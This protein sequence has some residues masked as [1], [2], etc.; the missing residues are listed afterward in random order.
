MV[1]IEQDVDNSLGDRKSR[2]YGAFP[3]SG[4]V[5]LPLA[6][7]NSGHQVADGRIAIPNPSTDKFRNAFRIMIDEELGRPPKAAIEAYSQRNGDV[8]EITTWFSIDDPAYVNDV[9]VGAIVYENKRVLL[10]ERFA[11]AAVESHVYPEPLPGKATQVTLETEPLIGVDWSKLRTVVY[12]ESIPGTDSS[13]GS[14][15]M[16]QAVV[17]SPIEFFVY[18]K[19][20]TLM[21]DPDHANQISFSPSLRGSSLLTWEVVEDLGW[22]AVD[23]VTAPVETPPTFTVVS[24]EL[25]P[26]WQSGVVDLNVRSDNHEYPLTEPISVRVFYGELERQY[27]PLALR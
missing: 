10:T 15:D 13:S 5:F 26:G 21:V 7:V 27:T 6:M 1:F 23:P 3:D 16:L 22:I 20:F 18:P 19:H 24:E 4:S 12:A 8:I 2:W 14:F 17:A 25:G 11:R 9:V